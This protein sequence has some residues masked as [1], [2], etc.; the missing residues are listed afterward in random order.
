MDEN[1]D[2]GVQINIFVGVLRLFLR[3]LYYDVFCRG[4]QN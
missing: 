3:S 4:P 2:K 1:I